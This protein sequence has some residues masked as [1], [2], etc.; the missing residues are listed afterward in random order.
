MFNLRGRKYLEAEK[1]QNDLHDLYSLPDII[2]MIKSREMRWTGH[3][4]P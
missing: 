2:R 1:M 4:A 3:V